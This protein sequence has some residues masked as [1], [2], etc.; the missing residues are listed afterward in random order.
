MKQ[1]DTARI[2]AAVDFLLDFAIVGYA[3][4]ATTFVMSWLG[5]HPDIRMHLHEVHNLTKH[6][7]V[8]MIENLYT[9]QEEPRTHEQKLHYGYKDPRDIADA[10]TMQSL[11]TYWPNTKLIVGVRHPVLWFQSKYNFR[12]RKGH[13]LPPATLLGTCER[14][15]AN[16]PLELAALLL[17]RKGIRDMYGFMCICAIIS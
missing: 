9:L 11:S 14:D 7:P 10:A 15:V 4:T 1:H 16:H 17:R 5:H 13:K 6:D 12:L 2:I 3:K 8:G